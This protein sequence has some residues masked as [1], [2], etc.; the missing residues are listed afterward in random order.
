MF[1]KNINLNQLL[2]LTQQEKSE[3]TK[4]ATFLN[5]DLKMETND[6]HATTAMVDLIEIDDDTPG[7]CVINVADQEKASKTK[8]AYDEEDECE[9]D[10]EPCLF[11]LFYEKLIKYFGDIVYTLE[12]CEAR[13]HNAMEENPA[14]ISSI[15][16]TVI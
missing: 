11:Q 8:V 5:T 1:K 2:D 10:D 16:N 3:T 12:A 14:I 15:N 9:D 6:S 7:E 13:Q 4:K